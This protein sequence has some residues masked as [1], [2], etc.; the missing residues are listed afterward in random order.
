MKMSC[1][2]RKE[3]FKVKTKDYEIMLPNHQ[4]MDLSNS[5]VR[6]SAYNAYE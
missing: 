5:K 4:L 1:Y 3:G 6:L 2:V